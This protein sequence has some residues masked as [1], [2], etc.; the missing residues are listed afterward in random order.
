MKHSADRSSCLK[1]APSL[2][3]GVIGATG[4]VGQELVRLLE[5][6]GSFPVGELV[7]FSS[8]SQRRTV[9]FR[10]RRLAAGPV[11]QAALAS[12]SL[13]FFV[14]SD[15]VSR[16]LAPGLAGRG[17]WTIDDSSA[18]RLD[19]GVPLVIPEVNAHVLK[20]SSRLIAGPNCTMTPLAV[21]A[22]ALHRGAGIKE[23]RLATYQSV[24]GAGRSALEEFFLQVHE[25]GRLRVEGRAPVLGGSAHSALP[26]PIAYNVIPQVGGFDAEGRS[27]EENKV[28][29]ELRKV[30]E[31][32]SLKVSVTAV[33]VPVVRGHAMAA[34]LTL[35]RPLSPAAARAAISRTPGLKLFPDG[36]Y[37]TPLAVADTEPVCVGRIRKGATSRELC[38]WLAY[39]NLLKGAA[40][41]SVQI[42]EE[43]LRRGWLA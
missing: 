6:R 4:M 37:P 26:G 7:P 15:E 14:S 35:G 40:L 23:V 24:S 1:K 36:D 39:D 9:S 25:K 31:A 10:G 30:W 11:D 3:V 13:V 41:N 18:F 42:A 22:V 38:L 33:R 27:V 43:L 12:C 28:A 29:G 32:P 8:G 2:R 20:R 34:W 5:R 19:P 17:I 16:R 21:A